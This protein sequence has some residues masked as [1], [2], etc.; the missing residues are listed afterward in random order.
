MS[1]PDPTQEYPAECTGC[2]KEFDPDAN[3]SL[4]YCG[5]GQC[6]KGDS[7]FG[8]PL[9]C[10]VKCHDSYFADRAESEREREVDQAILDKKERSA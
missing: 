8:D 7:R 1:H 10:D 9:F 2:G 6:E 5:C 3:E 4:G